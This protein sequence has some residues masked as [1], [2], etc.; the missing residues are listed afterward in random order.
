MYYGVGA[1]LLAVLVWGVWA[2]F[3]NTKPTCNDG[4]QNGAE[5][6]VDCGGSCALICTVTSKEP[7]VLWARPFKSGGNTYTVAAY[8]K[9]DNIGAG[10]KNVAYSFQL[11]DAENSLVLEREGTVNLP[12]V[13]TIPII[14]TNINVGTRSVSRVQFAFTKV[15]PAVW[16]KVPQGSIPTLRTAQQ[17]LSSDASRL[18][19]N[20]LNSGLSDVKNV[21]A[22][23]VLFDAQGVARAASKSLVTLVPARGFASLVF[24]WPGGIPNIVRAEITLLPSF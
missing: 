16:S 8:V 1:V 22:V 23:A 13:Q 15:P 3:F 9:N 4:V 12:P 11:F 17:N 24:T 20:V 6:G 14:E 10:A 2:T 18:N 7:T 19:A 5:L 21:T